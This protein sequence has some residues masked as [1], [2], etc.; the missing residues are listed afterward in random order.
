M[1]TKRSVGALV[2]VCLSGSFALG[3][4]DDGPTF[5]QDVAPILEKNC[6]TC[7]QSGGIAPFSLTS[8][9]AAKSHAVRIAEATRTR[10]M[11]PMPVN[12]DGSCNTYSNARWL[13][14]DE[15][16]TIGEWVEQD[17][18]E[19]DG[20]VAIEPPPVTARVQR[21]RFLGRLELDPRRA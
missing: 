12:N 6:V 3:C 15:I 21:S 16:Q 7:H 1:K 18:P 20:A 10:E 17:A 13:T 5:A 4:A 2:G 19:G 14:E 9:D 8:Y 11:P